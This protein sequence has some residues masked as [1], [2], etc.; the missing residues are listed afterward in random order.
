MADVSPIPSLLKDE[1]ILLQKSFDFA[2]RIIKMYQWLIEKHRIYSLADQILRSGTSIGANSEEAIGGY[3]IRNFAAKIGNSYKEARETRYW[4]RL[5]YGSGY[6]EKPMFDSMLSDCEELIR[7]L[8][9][10]KKTTQH[11]IRMETDKK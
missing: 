3:S 7:I 11:K 4:L 8:G 6:I 1:N 10:I 5:L 2:L 9:S